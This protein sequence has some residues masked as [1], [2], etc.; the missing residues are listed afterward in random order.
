MS[1]NVIVAVG[2]I[3][4]D[5]ITISEADGWRKTFTNLPKY[6]VVNIKTN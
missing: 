5:T 2:N 1:D 4:K 6:N 3:V